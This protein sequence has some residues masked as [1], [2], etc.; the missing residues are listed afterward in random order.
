M[1]LGPR[2]ARTYDLVERA[3][4][5]EVLRDVPII[6]CHAHMGRWHNFYVP[7]GEAEGMIATMDACGIDVAC[8]SHHLAL[9][10]D[11]EEGNRL[12]FEAAARYPE[13]LRAYITVNP[14]R[15]RRAVEAEMAKWLGAEP[16]GIKL[17]PSVHQANV[18]DERMTPVWEFA[19]EHRV[20]VLSHVWEGCAYGSPKHFEQLGERRPRVRFILGHSG[21]S[22]GGI[23]ASIEVAKRLRNV[24]LDLT[25]S[26]LFY[27][28]LERMVAEVGASRILFGTDL[29]FIDPR[30]QL[31][32]VLLA[33]L[34]DS[35]KVKILGANAARLFRLRVGGA[36]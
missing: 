17:H 3:R 36:E 23:L 10:P 11:E 35:R 4:G 30:F 15:E 16:C 8:C 21:G 18:L 2:L 14:N 34:P 32:R 7:R 19:E 6:D 22:L 1:S 27:G 9:A 26:Q 5:G 28:I 33:R 20:P 13:R 29:P 12:A 24:Y 25:G 31:G